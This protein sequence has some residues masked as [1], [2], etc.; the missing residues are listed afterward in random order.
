YVSEGHAADLEAQTRAF[1]VYLPGQN[2]TM[3]PEALADDLCSL[4]EGMDRPAL[5]C[6]LDINADG[7]LGD[8]RFCA[9]TVRS[10]ARLAHH[11]VPAWLEGRGA[12]SRQ[13]EIGAH[14]KAL[15]RLTQARS[16]WRAEHALLP[17]DRPDYV[18]ELDTAGNVLDVRIE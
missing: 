8:Y 10:H 2:V 13:G 4:K 11:P 17:K 16:A 3:L 9:A 6:A 1:T 7:S 15:A 14:L 18:L 12:W 5:V